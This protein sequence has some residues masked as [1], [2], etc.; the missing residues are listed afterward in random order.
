MKMKTSSVPLMLILWIFCWHLGPS[1]MLNAAEEKAEKSLYHRLGGYD[2]IAVVI[3][4]FF[5]RIRND[6][7]FA[8]FTHGRSIDSLQ[9][10]RQLLVEQLCMATG[11]PCVYIGRELKTAHAGLG[12]TERE[13]EANLKHLTASLDTCKVPEKERDELLALVSSFKKDIVEPPKP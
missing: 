5:G 4:D 2:T 12:I 9:R 6:P 11:G 7:Q 8:R 1:L 13:W 10:A 3:D